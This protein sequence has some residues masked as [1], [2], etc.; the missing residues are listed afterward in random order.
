MSRCL[1]EMMPTVTEPPRPNGLPMAITTSPTFRP[2]GRAER[3]GWQRLFSA[4]PEEGE[5]GLG[6]L[7][8]H[9]LDLELGAVVEVDDDLVGAS[10]T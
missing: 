5:V 8:Q 1:A 10:M 6:V 2:V 9:L 4:S 7:A 3:H